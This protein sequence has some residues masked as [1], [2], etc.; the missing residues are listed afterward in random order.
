MCGVAA[1]EQVVPT[2]LLAW[3][4]ANWAKWQGDYFALAYKMTAKPLHDTNSN[5]Q[6]FGEPR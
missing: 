4:E 6:A 5:K 3:S 2:S 1:A